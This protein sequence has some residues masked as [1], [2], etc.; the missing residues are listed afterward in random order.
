LA[1]ISEAEVSGPLRA[2]IV[3]DSERD[4]ALLV[5]ELR[6]GYDLS[7]E[8]VETPDAVTSAK[9]ALLRLDGG[10]LF[11]L[12]LCDLMMPEMSGMDLHRRLLQSAPD[13]AAKITFMTGGAFTENT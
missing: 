2:L 1:G 3:E 4:A 8:R 7:F 5:R 6:R 10:E 11:D 12:I 13:Q 9:E